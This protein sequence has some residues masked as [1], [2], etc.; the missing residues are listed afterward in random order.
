MM[1]H[2]VTLSLLFLTA[3]VAPAQEK[4]AKP[5]KP[6]KDKATAKKEAIDF[7]KQIW[8]ILEKR[9]IEC[10]A[11]PQPNAEGKPKKPKGG[12]TLDSKSGITSSKGGKLVIAKNANDSKLVASISLP[13]DDEDRMPPAKKG[14]P[15]AKDQI[16]LIKSWIDQGAE[17]GSWTGKAAAKDAP[18]DKGE[19]EGSKPSEKDK[20]G[21]DK[22][23]EKD[24]H[25][26]LGAGLQPLPAAV[27]ATFADGPFLVQSLGDGSPLL[28]IN[29]AGRTDDVDDTAL[30]K[31]APLAQH[32]TELDLGHTHVTDEGC[33]A[34]AKMPRLTS[35]DLRQ[36]AVS[37]HGTAAL[38]ACKE[39]RTLNLF[40][41]K[42]GDYG[43]AALGDLKHLENL[44][45]WQT[46]V[47]AAALVRLRETL[48]D[49]R[50]VVAAD[51]PEPMTET[52]AGGRRRGA[53]K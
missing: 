45:V 53:A 48:P 23:K 40:G 28:S 31:L 14:E 39:L 47:S 35:L 38:A 6:E 30:A 20:K 15:L 12:V 33:A 27:L 22:E 18:K 4:P 50:V 24:H 11:T 1:K 8:P 42:A 46:D 19:K 21:K 37:N 34:L 16:D 44:Y 3:A 51:L 25:T 13:A 26:A 7:E 9:C 5:D 32:V 2:L 36:T 49:G 43:V 41:T 52:P 17:F 10:H 29:C